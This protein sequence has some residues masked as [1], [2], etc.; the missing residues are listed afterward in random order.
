MDLF[1][2]SVLLQRENDDDTTTTSHHLHWVE[3][4]S[5]DDAIASAIKEAKRTKPELNVVDV[6]CGNTKTGASKRVALS[7][8]SQSVY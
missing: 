3:A 8:S 6:L 7:D 4:A 2:A 5:M 1:A